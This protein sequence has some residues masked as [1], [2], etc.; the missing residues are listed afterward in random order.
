MDHG[1]ES[2][3][4]SRAGGF[5]MMNGWHVIKTMCIVGAVL[6]LGGFARAG[7]LSN[8]R[9][10]I[11][12]VMTDDQGMNGLA[13]LGDKEIKTPHLDRFYAQ[14]TRFTDFQVSPTCS[15]TRSA[16]MSGRVPFKNGVTHT[17]FQRERM[18]LDTFTVAQALKS[19]GYETGIFGKWHLG[20]EEAYLPGNRGFNEVLI[21]GAG[22]IGQVQYG[23]FPPNGKNPYFD[24]VLLHNDTIVQTKGFCTDLFFHAALAWI[25][26]QNEAKVPYFAYVALNAPHAPMIAPEKYKKRFLDR[27]Y[28]ETTAGRYGMIENIDDN[29]GLMMK[30][31]DEWQALDN[32]LIIFMTDNGATHLSGTRNG[33]AVKHFNGNLK[34]AK[35]S[36]NEGGTHV[37]AFWQ[38]KG[39]LGDSD[40]NALVA[41]IDLYKTFCELAGVKLP[42]KMQ[43]L[44]GRSLLPL[45]ENPKADWPDRELFI[46]CG[47]WDAGER[48][49]AKFKQCAVRTDR[50]R[51]VNNKDLYDISKDPGETTEESALY[52]EVI[53]QL[54][55]SYDKWW[56]SVLPLMVNEGLPKVEPEDQP[57]AI[58][59]EKQ[60]KEKGIPDWAPDKL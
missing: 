29:F 58:R 40:V 44:D 14:A 50:W 9:P 15:P 19:A 21:H 59:Y 8:S 17:I 48:D 45:L 30:K 22:G 53:D 57:L 16:M 37:P 33:K 46:H 42:A 60:L 35:N 10:N 7:A 23:D 12:L 27:G 1:E 24:N 36:P 49:A 56:E 26:Q 20:D 55:K 52:P 39:V 3:Q 41:H 54:R 13:C 2:G 47:R 32:T 51:F 43:E 6:T 25:K 31:L 4:G 5:S 38:W 11:I 34:G 18:A 28:D